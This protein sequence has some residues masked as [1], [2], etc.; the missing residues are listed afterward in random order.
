MTESFAWS[1]PRL[2]AKPLP[3]PRPCFFT[4]KPGILA[5]Q[6]DS[7]LG[8]RAN[9]PEPRHLASEFLQPPSLHTHGAGLSQT[10]LVPI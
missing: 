5:T 10:A 7:S 6:S 2:G 3:C 4:Q 9:P 8:T 1:L